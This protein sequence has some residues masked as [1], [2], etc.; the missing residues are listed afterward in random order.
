[1]EG[2]YETK[3][4]VLIRFGKWQE[5]IDEP[6]PENPTLFCVTTANWRYA[7]GIAYAVLGDV[8]NVIE[9]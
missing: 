2:L 8:D 1:M 6:M 3:A 4:Y 9:Q 5:I 7:K